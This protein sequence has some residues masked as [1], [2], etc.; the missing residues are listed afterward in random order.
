MALGEGLCGFRTTNW[1]N[2]LEG[3]P[4]GPSLLS[5]E[6]QGETPWRLGGSW[7]FLVLPPSP[8]EIEVELTALKCVA[9]RSEAF[10]PTP[11]S[12]RVRPN[13]RPP[14]VC[15]CAP[16]PS[17]PAPVG[18]VDPSTEHEH[19]TQ[20]DPAARRPCGA[21]ARSSPPLPGPKVGR[22]IANA[23]KSSVYE[24]NR[25]AVGALAT[26]EMEEWVRTGPTVHSMAIGQTLRVDRLSTRCHIIPF[27]STLQ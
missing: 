16:S 18:L 23:V 9:A 5:V 24:R 4:N 21:F 15:S 11:R 14:P 12:G 10:G 7:V 19:P 8:E 22:P 6:K 2:D 26:T 17:P 3:G 1:P 13:S 20:C 27:R 25:E